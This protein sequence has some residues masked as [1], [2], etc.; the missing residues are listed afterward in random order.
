MRKFKAPLIALNLVALVV[1]FIY[2]VLHKEHTLTSGRLIFLELAPVDPRSLMQGDYMQLR[3]RLISEMDDNVNCHA[4]VCAVACN[5]SSIAYKLRLS[6]VN[7][8]T[9]G[10]DECLLKYGCNDNE[11]HLG[12]ES[13]FFEE[14]QGEKYDSARYGGLRVDEDG[15]SVLIGLFDARLNQIK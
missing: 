5:D 13:Y 11:L 14:G 10:K 1:F 7:G 3:Y 2:S 6:G 12:A 15:N 8:T 9:L 4:G